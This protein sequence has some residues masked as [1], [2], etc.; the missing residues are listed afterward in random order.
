MGWFGKHMEKINPQLDVPAGG[1][2]GHHN[3][4]R[5]NPVPDV[6][7][8]PTYSKHHGTPAKVSQDPSYRKPH[9]KKKP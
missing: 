1:S 8:E 9:G 6:A 2:R 5:I 7:S 4:A 3:M